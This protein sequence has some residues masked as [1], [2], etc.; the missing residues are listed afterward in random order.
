M[1]AYNYF[2]KEERQKILK[3]VLAEDPSKVENDPNSGDY[4]DDETF[5]RL[6]KDGNKVS[7]DQM[8]KVIG[9]RWKNI[10]PDRLAKYSEMASEDA[11][12]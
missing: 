4:I 10:D 8:G 12:R 5:K 11:E 2:F 1:S 3:Y 6:K 9:Q 7:F